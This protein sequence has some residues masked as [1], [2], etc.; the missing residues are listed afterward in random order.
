MDLKEKF[1]RQI[2]DAWLTAI[3]QDFIKST[4]DREVSGFCFAL[5]DMLEKIVHSESYE[6][7]Q[8]TGYDNVKNNRDF[9]PGDFLPGE[10][11]EFTRLYHQYG[12][13]D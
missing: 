11:E 3:D 4:G 7:A 9:I 13:R 1:R 5:T 8:F 10:K 12:E 6:R 2:H